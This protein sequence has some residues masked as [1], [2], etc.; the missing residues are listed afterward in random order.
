MWRTLVAT[1]AA[2][3]W[4]TA[5][6]DNRR[7]HHADVRAP[8]AVDE[9]RTVALAEA[10]VL[11]MPPLVRPD[12]TILVG[13][14]GVVR[15]HGTDDRTAWDKLDGR[16]YAL[17]TDLAP[18]WENALDPVPWCYHYQDR[19]EPGQCPDGGMVNW[20]NGTVEGT[21]TIVDDTLYVGRGD[22]KLYALDVDSGATRW[23]FQ[24]FNPLDPAD[25]DGGGE[26]I[27]APTVGP[28]GTIYLA[29][30]A[31]GPYET[32]AVYA[33]WPDGTLRWRYPADAST[34]P[35][36]FF[37]DP[38]LSPDGSRLYVGGAWGPT[39][40]DLGP[41]AV[42]AI[43]AFDLDAESV[44]WVYEPVNAEEWWKPTVWTTSLAVGTDGTLYLA[45]PEYTLAGGSAV[46]WALSDDGDHA[47]LAW[48]YVDLDRD[49]AMMAFG[50]ALD[51]EDGVTTRVVV[52][53]GHTFN[54]FVLSYPEGGILASLDAATGDVQWTLDPT[55]HGWSGSPQNVVLDDAGSAVVAVSGTVDGGVVAAIDRN[56]QHQWSEQVV[57]LLEWGGPVLGPSGEVVVGDSRRCLFDAA[58]VEDGLC[59]QS[60]AWVTVLAGPAAPDEI[61]GPD[62][63]CAHG[64]PSAMFLLGPLL[65]RRR[66]AT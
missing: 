24:T 3:G 10:R 59:P 39:V 56:G 16:V 62:C 17:D 66:R 50:L 35:Q 21:P 49:Q 53:S 6:F 29:T 9:V 1:A 57:G 44:A 4:T 63:G 7:T 13:S 27:A 23:V 33:V 37:A 15:D 54:P 61:G 55:D 34:L 25:P 19:A 45:G 47:T 22:G 30:V 43:Y 60:D 8:D 51:E 36:V 28:D 64:R 14:W 31:A 18:L 38:A 41:D 2:S 65:L 5:G 58:P 52:T 32:S 26:V 48:G 20:Y 11:N 42:G 12:G 46:A 40:E